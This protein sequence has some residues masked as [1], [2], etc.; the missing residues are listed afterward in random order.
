MKLVLEILFSGQTCTLNTN[1][2]KNRLTLPLCT[3][4][5]KDLD[6]S[7]SAWATRKGRQFYSCR[8]LLLDKIILM[9]R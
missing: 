7:T 2:G 4:H 6:Y 1:V 9:F 3:L 5:T 8:I